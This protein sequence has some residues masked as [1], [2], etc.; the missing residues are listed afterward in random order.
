MLTK[1][2]YLTT[3]LAILFIAACTC[4]T[5]S[6]QAQENLR[7]S[8]KAGKFHFSIKTLYNLNTYKDESPIGFDM[9]IGLN[10][11][12]N[13]TMTI[14]LM[15]YDVYAHGYTKFDENEV[16]V[17]GSGGVGFFMLGLNYEYG[18][19]SVSQ[20]RFLQKIF[21]N[22]GI[23]IVDYKESLFCIS[24]GPEYKIPISK[25][26]SIPIGLKF[27]WPI[28]SVDETNIEKWDFVGVHAG[29]TFN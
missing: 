14:G 26:V 20:N 28:N 15:R 12:Q 17:V 21:I 1:K 9:R 25:S 27:V 3:S 5:F 29:I 6:Q 19:G 8:T 16:T 11:N 23:Y 24:L 18:L 2:F 7:S 13:N 10:F 4:R 22:G